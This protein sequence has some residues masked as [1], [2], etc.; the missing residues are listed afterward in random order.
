MGTWMTIIEIS[1]QRFFQLEIAVSRDYNSILTFECVRNSNW[2]DVSVLSGVILRTWR[3]LFGDL[4]DNLGHPVVRGDTSC[5]TLVVQ[6]QI[7]S[8]WDLFW[9]AL[10]N[11]F[12]D[13]LDTI[14]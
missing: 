5:D 9:G 14:L 7:L 2:D 1:I 6:T 10:G 13:S 11:N 3:L 4:D 12:R 8:I